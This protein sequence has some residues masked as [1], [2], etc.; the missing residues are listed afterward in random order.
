M[1]V[2]GIFP[3]RGPRTPAHERTRGQ[4]G[5]IMAGSPPHQS[6]EHLRTDLRR[7]NQINNLVPHDRP[8]KRPAI[9][10]EIEGKS[11]VIW[12]EL[13]RSEQ[14]GASTQRQC[15]TGSHRSRSPATR[16]GQNFPLVSGSGSG[17][18]CAGVTRCVPR[19][20]Q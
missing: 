20:G 4:L 12:S 9:R 11:S 13:P 6:R 19:R 14:Y 5:S 7:Q 17:I 3:G 15:A 16:R 10:G 1:R 18:L 8:V 2:L